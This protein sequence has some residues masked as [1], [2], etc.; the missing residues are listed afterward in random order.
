MAGFD[1]RVYGVNDEK[2]LDYAA[3]LGASGFTCNYF[4]AAY[5]WAKSV[6]GLTLAPHWK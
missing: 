5:E 3:G 1:F 2:L 6:P 4:K